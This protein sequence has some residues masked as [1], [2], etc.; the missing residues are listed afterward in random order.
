MIHS[1]AVF[2]LR[3]ANKELISL[4]QLAVT[5]IFHKWLIIAHV[6]NL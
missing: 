3:L 1:V 2:T 4:E 6:D 5:L